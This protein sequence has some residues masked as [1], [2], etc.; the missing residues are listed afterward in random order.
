NSLLIVIL[1]EVQKTGPDPRKLISDPGYGSCSVLITHYLT[2]RVVPQH[3]VIQIVE[4]RLSNESPVPIGVVDFSN[5]VNVF[6]LRFH[7]RNHPRPEGNRHHLGHVA[8]ESIDTFAHPEQQNVPHLR[9]CV[10]Y[11]I[12][13]LTTVSCDINA[14]IELY[15][16][17]P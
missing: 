10:G 14:I 8:P 11:G 7:L 1:K 3:F 9:P 15:R 17:E 5:K 2:E 16:V 4:P 6:P 13:I 12:E